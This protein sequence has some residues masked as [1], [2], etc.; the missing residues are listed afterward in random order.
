MRLGSSGATCWTKTYT[1]PPQ[2]T[3]CFS[4]TDLGPHYQ[5]LNLVKVA[6]KLL[7]SLAMYVASQSVLSVC[8]HGQVGR[9]VADMGHR[10]T[11]LVPVFRAYHLPPRVWTWWA[12]T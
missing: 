3:C 4:P 12:S 8:A 9:L 2:T 7:R 5:F 6:F 1:W 11:C 10:V